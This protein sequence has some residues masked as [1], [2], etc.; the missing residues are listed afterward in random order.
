MTARPGRSGA[1][2][3]TNVNAGT[4]ARVAAAARSVPRTEHDRL[5]RRL[6]MAGAGRDLRALSEILTSDAIVVSDVGGS[7]PEGDAIVCGAEDAARLV[8]AVLGH[9]GTQP[10]LVEINGRLGIVVSRGKDVVAV[11]APEAS[12]EGIAAIWIVRNP[13]KLRTWRSS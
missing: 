13:A 10:T 9:P 2:A 6:I 11:V 8:A 3:V 7:A 5:T 1:T 12:L 4:L